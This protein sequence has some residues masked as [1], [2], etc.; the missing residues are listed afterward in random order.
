MGHE[1]KLF[2]P[3]TSLIAMNVPLERFLRL[4]FS[5]SPKLASRV[6]MRTARDVLEWS[7][8]LTISNDG[9]LWPSTVAKIRSGGSP[10]TLWFPDAIVNVDRQ[11]MFLAPYDRLFFKDPY[12]VRYCDEVTGLPARF[13]PEACDPTVHHP[14]EPNDAERSE[15]A[16]E[17]ALIGNVAPSR[18]KLLEQLM[19]Y[20][21][22][23]WSRIYPRWIDSPTRDRWTGEFLIGDRKAKAM[24]SSKIVLNNLHYGEIEGSNCRLF[25]AAGCGAFQVAEWRKSM[26][27][28]FEDGGEIVYYRTADE[29]RKVI[30]HY[31]PL[32]AERREIGDAARVRAHSEHTYELRLTRLIEESL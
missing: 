3:K 24:R 5:A 22:R 12:F 17:I 25:E 27:D 9:G 11:F 29:L 4:A 23:I 32:E 21:L 28:F 19:D 14:I 30:D 20:D 18:V 7:P 15:L 1:S 26:D 31:L 8:D 13:L 6:E 2:V 16:A 10:V